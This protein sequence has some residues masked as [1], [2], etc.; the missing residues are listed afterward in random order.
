MPSD[1]THNGTERD[2]LSRYLRDYL[3]EHNE[4]ERGLARRATDPDTKLTLQHGWI[5]QLAIGRMSRAPEIWRL[6]AL[7]VAMGVPVR[8]LAELAAAQWLGV[9]VAEVAGAGTDWV[10][11]SLPA[12][13]SPKERERFV[14]M[15]EDIARHFGK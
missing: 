10:A 9:E 8:L 11:V 6:R 13:L 7:A 12:G 3:A 5:N 14:A 4:S 1:G 2:R 15:A